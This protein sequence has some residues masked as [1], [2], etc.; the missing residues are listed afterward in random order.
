MFTVG[1]DIYIDS[2]E[3]VFCRELG[4]NFSLINALQLIFSAWLIVFDVPNFHE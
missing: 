2:A 1:S 3:K 4:K